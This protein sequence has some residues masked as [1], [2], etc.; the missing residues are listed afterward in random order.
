MTALQGAGWSTAVKSAATRNAA[1]D[2]G[3][4]AL[5]IQAILWGNEGN[6]GQ[7]PILLPAAGQPHGA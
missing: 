5:Q 7:I 3:Q 1:P 2:N 4:S 6:K